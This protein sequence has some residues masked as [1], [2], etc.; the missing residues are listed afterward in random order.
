MRLR[1]RKRR[2]EKEYGRQNGR[3]RNM[4]EEKGREGETGKETK[5][6]E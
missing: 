4:V 1:M 6:R 3:R 5:K 2:E